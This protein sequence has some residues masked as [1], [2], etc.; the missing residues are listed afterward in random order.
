MYDECYLT[1][2][3]DVKLPRFELLSCRQFTY[4]A[5]IFIVQLSEEFI[6]KLTLKT[7]FDE[8]KIENKTVF[9]FDKRCLPASELIT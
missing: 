9:D 8:F 5:K 1:E 3:Y 2:L 6:V 4:K 7:V